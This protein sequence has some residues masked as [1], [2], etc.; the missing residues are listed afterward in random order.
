MGW[1]KCKNNKKSGS[2]YLDP[3]GEWGWYRCCSGRIVALIATT[4]V[5]GGKPIPI[6]LTYYDVPC[7]RVASCEDLPAFYPIIYTSP[8]SHLVRMMAQ[9]S[10]LQPS[11]YFD[12]LGVFSF[13]RFFCLYGNSGHH[14]VRPHSWYSSTAVQQYCYCCRAT[15][16][17]R[18]KW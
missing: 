12:F 8:I 13:S 11:G 17:A 9:A 1:K 14:S 15:A 18:Y 5:R 3:A 16:G 2:V 4:R 10:Y 7:V 6:P